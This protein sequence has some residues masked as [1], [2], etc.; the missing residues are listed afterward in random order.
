MSM[1]DRLVERRGTDSYKWDDVGALFGHEDILP[2]WVA[3]MDFAVP[4]PVLA[5][6]RRRAEHPVFGYESRGDSIRD[7]VTQ[8]LSSRHDWTV[9]RDWLMFCPPSAI[10]GIYGLVTRLCPKGSAVAC[11]TPGYGPLL[12]L[13]EDTGRRLV[14]CPLIERQGRFHLDVDDMRQRLDADVKMLLLCNPHNPTGRVFTQ[15]ELDDVAGLAIERDMFV[16][17][18]EVHCDLTMP[19]HR[20]IPFGKF[21]N[22]RA[23]TV[24]SPNKTFNTAGLPHTTFVIP[25]PAMRAVFARFLDTLQLNHD[26]TFAAA[27]AAAAYRDCAGWLD[28]LIGYLDGNHRLLAAYLHSNVPTVQPVP[29]EGTYLAWLDCRQT[30]FAEDELMRRLVEIGRVGLYPGSTFGREGRGFLRMNIACP[31]ETLQRGLDG[32]ARALG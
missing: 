17:S 5:A 2:F 9:P 29:A 25:D 12:G 23:A 4:E 20:H 7:A 22:T 1:F 3:D 26:S 30:G 10:V 18:D 16:V 15:A 11:H 14:R 27:A 21:A 32:I 31:R 19:G 8:W 13:I 24:I 6:V 28:E